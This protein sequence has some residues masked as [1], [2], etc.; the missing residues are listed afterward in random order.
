MAR[1]R[2]RRAAMVAAQ[3]EDVPVGGPTQAGRLLDPE[4]GNGGLALAIGQVQVNERLPHVARHWIPTASS[5][6]SLPTT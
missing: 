5:F 2:R 6:M 1:Q 3:G 4:D